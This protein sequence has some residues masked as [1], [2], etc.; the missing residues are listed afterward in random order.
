VIELDCGAI[1]MKAFDRLENR[2]YRDENGNNRNRTEWRIDVYVRIFDYVIT[3]Q[4]FGDLVRLKSALQ[5]FIQNYWRKSSKKGLSRIKLNVEMT[6]PKFDQILSLIARQKNNEHY[7]QIT[8]KD[9]EEGIEKSV[10]LDGQEAIMI[11]TALGKMIN[12]TSPG[13]EEDQ[14]KGYYVFDPT[15]QG[16]SA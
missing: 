12:L 5:F 11:D 6:R 3:N 7:L 9:V 8:Y 2:S 16:R 10:Y 1:Y 14:A 15:L 4:H 13:P